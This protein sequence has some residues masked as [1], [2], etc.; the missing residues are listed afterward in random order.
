[1]SID[2]EILWEITSDFFCSKTMLV[3][4]YV[5]IGSNCNF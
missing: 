3:N 1:M 2:D 5:N 4:V